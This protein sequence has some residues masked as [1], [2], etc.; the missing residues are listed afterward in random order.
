MG[1]FKVIVK[2]GDNTSN[3]ITAPTPDTEYEAPQMFLTPVDWHWPREMQPIHGV[4]DGF[5]D[6]KADW[7]RT[8]DGVNPDNHIKHNWQG[9]TATPTK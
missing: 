1:G 8:K 2:K 6:W 9:V 4:Y 3:I 7:W 5:L